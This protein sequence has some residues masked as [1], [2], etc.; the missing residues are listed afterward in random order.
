MKLGWRAATNTLTAWLVCINILPGK[1]PENLDEYWIQAIHFSPV[2]IE[3]AQL[4]Q[5]VKIRQK[6]DQNNSWNRRNVLICLQQFDQF[7]IWM[8][9]DDRKRKLSMW[10]CRKYDCKNL[11]NHFGWTYFWRVLA[12]WNHRCCIYIDSFFYY[13]TRSSSL[14]L[15]SV[16]SLL[17]SK[18]RPQ[19]HG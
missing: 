8:L 7:W 14:T 10:I 6:F 2:W 12:I 19:F 1:I 5:I 11:W 4:Y 15:L 13:G 17:L 9:C 3:Q 18:S 16:F